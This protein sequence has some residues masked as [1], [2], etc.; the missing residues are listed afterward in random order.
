[1]E[2]PAS[3]RRASLGRV[4]GCLAVVQGAALGVAAQSA[5]AGSDEAAGPPGG[6]PSPIAGTTLSQAI[7]MLGMGLLVVA[8]IA[9]TWL[10]SHKF[11]V[12]PGKDDDA[13]ARKRLSSSDGSSDASGSGSDA[14]SDS[15]SDAEADLEMGG[16]V[17]RAGSAS[18]RASNKVA[19]LPSLQSAPAGPP[20]AAPKSLLAALSA[21]GAGGAAAAAGE[22]VEEEEEED[23]DDDDAEDVRGMDGSEEE[24]EEQAAVATTSSASASAAAGPSVAPA[25]ALA[26]RPLTKSGRAARKRALGIARAF[27]RGADDPGYQAVVKALAVFHHARTS[28]KLVEAD[29]AAI[30]AMSDPPQAVMLAL[31]AAALL[32][33]N[34]TMNPSL[35]SK[36]L[37]KFHEGN[38][39]KRNAVERTSV[40]WVDLSLRLMRPRNKFF[41]ELTRMEVEGA[42]MLKRAAAA[43]RRLL[44]VHRDTLDA[45]RVRASAP[46]AVRILAWTH[47]TVGLL[48]V[49]ETCPPRVR[50]PA[51]AAL[52][53]PAELREISREAE[54]AG[55][56]AKAAFEAHGAAAVSEARS[57]WLNAR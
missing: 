21:M 43:V 35:F 23:D 29:L 11:V 34:E 4:W 8:G 39:R 50:K 36:K 48:D 12:I 25:G 14:G 44:Q 37:V 6:L 46:A 42:F 10:F 33:G 22:E 9:F 31:E 20:A 24:L 19:P 16:G 41:L 1:M 56:G 51:F 47:A 40:D 30:R 7:V 15:A 54:R 32:L 13:A 49:L 18:G 53:R 55:L 57:L 26:T 17:R 27:E 52:H 3:G 2:G 28:L 38:F 45:G 5:D